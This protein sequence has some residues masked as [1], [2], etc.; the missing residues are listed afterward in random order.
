M[1][2][3]PNH[4]RIAQTLLDQQSQI[5]TLTAERDGAYRERAQLLALL[6][7]MAHQP[8]IVPAT[9]V[10]D[11]GWQILYLYI[12]GRQAS[13]HIAPRDADLFTHVED[14]DESSPLAWWDGHTTEEK[15]ARIADHI[16]HRHF[17]PP[18]H[19]TS[20]DGTPTCVHA[21]PVG[22]DS[23]WTCRTLADTDQPRES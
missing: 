15:Y 4:P 16:V 18:A 12:G 2:E 20:S 9:D 7:A 11:P 23:C 5:N 1:P 10:E 21:I 3:Y 13:W 19:Y 8:A 14:R 6:A 22:P 17:T